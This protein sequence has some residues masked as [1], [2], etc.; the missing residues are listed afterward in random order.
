MA[1][2]FRQE[3]IL[4]IKPLDHTLMKLLINGKFEKDD[5]CGI[6]KAPFTDTICDL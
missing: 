2:I 6:P 1:S 3:P 4:Y 5:I